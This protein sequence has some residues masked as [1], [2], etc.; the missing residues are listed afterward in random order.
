MLHAVSDRSA[1]V[2]TL[3]AQGRRALRVFPIV[4]PSHQTPTYRLLEKEELEHVQISEID[5]AG[6]VPTLKVTN[7]LDERIYLM[8]GQH[9]IGARQ[10]RMLNSDVLVPAR[11]TITIPVSC[12]EMGR[13]GYTTQHFTPDRSASSNIRRRAAMRTTDALRE[14][15][16]HDADQDCVWDDVADMLAE[17]DAESPTSAMGAAYEKRAANLDAFRAQFT[18]PDDAVGLA[19]FYRDTLLG[20]DLF[21]RHATLEHYWQMLLDSYAIDW[22]VADASDDDPATSPDAAAVKTILEQAAAAEWDRFDSPGEGADYRLSD[23]GL[24]GSSLI[25]DERIA[26]HVQLFPIGPNDAEGARRSPSV[27]RIRR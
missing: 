2:R 9:L 17:S 22:S 12:V 10:N 5:E 6:D 13:W 4:G 20:L 11:T 16:G 27:R 26:V 7:P 21:D 23:S 14:Q 25:W 8:Q 24:C 19:V 1:V 3:D 15:R 18:L